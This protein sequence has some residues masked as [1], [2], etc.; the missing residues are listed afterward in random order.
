[1]RLRDTIRSAITSWRSRRWLRSCSH[2]GSDP[3]LEGKPTIGGGS[4]IRIGE[5]FQLASVVSPSHMYTASGG[6]LEIG[7]DVV[8]GHGAAIAAYKLVRIGSGT[9]IAP[10]V[11][12]L[13]TDFH[14]VA[15]RSAPGKTGAIVIGRGVR[16][17]SHV[18]VL[19]GTEIGD[20]AVIGAGSVVSGKVLP[21]ARVSV[22]PGDAQAHRPAAASGASGC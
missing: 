4:R 11:T 14:G 1:M 17:G 3:R 20:G 8:I 18:I 2:V 9:R 22:V 21:G 5:R 7:D 15:D 6:T 19:R 13:D 10:H 16:I 12:I